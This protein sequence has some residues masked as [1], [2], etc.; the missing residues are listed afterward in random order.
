[1]ITLDSRSRKT[2]T[3]SIFPLLLAPIGL[4]A[5]GSAAAATNYYVR[6]DGG[7]AT[8]CTGK[9]DAPYSGS[10][11]GQ[12]CAWSHPYFALPSTGTPRIAGGDTLNIGSGEYMIGYGAPGM[13]GECAAGDRNACSL[14]KIPS[15]TSSAKTRILGNKAKPPKLWGAERTWSVLD[16]TGSN[17]VEVGHLEI[18]DK[19]S[20][21]SAHSTA[22]AAC[23]RS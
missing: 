7:T 1:M 9:A 12:A 2:W 23:N 14:G 20:C 15:G 4:A 16:L 6:T 17:N 10:G 18:T 21:I 13:A 11:N 19:S 5:W 22:G 3:R 8:Q